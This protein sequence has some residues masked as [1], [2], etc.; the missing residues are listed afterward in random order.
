[1]GYALNEVMQEAPGRVIVA[2]F[3][4]NI[5]RIQQVMD[6]AARFGRK[7]ALLG[8]SM[9]A[10]SRIALELGYLQ[11][12]R[13]V[14]V[15][16]ESLK[17]LADREVVLL[18]TGTQGEPLSGLS[19]MARREHKQITIKPGDTVVLSS[20]FIPGNERAIDWLI[21][22]FYRQ[23]AEVI[24][25]KVSDI[26]VS[27][28][29]SR[30]ELKMMISITRPQYFI[31]IH[32]EYRH[33][34]RHARLAR[35]MGVPEERVLVAEDGDIVIFDEIGGERVGRVE[36]G[37]QVVDGTCVADHE[38]GVLQERRRLANDG[39][40][41]AA[42]RLDPASGMIAG[43]IQLKSLGL[44]YEEESSDALTAARLYAETELAHAT[45][46]AGNKEALADAMRAALKRYIKKNLSRFPVIIPVVV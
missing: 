45:D 14:M 7:V 28:H 1:V 3:A 23:G 26:H 39:I 37:R 46:L 6:A 33:L 5:H 2:M 9:E 18:T 29:A 36:S 43:P 8:R 11:I 41:I 25:E 10:N 38:D 44:F 27:G 16:P 24:Y 21:N 12:P 20:R 30:E 42:A 31:P 13:G 19:R 15:A 32:G 17:R 34:V 35:E 4:S 40:L 22:Q